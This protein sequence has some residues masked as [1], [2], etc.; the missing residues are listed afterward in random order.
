VALTFPRDPFSGLI[1]GT[2]FPAHPSFQASPHPLLPLLLHGVAYGY[3]AKVIKEGSDIPKMMEKGLKGGISF[4][5][6]VLPAAI[7]IHLFN[8]SNL[9]TVLAVTEPTG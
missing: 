9:A 2:S 7:F 5:V 1:T 8:A 6:V 4:L 3:G